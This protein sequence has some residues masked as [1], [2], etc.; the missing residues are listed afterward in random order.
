MIQLLPKMY[1]LIFRNIDPLS[2]DMVVP[3]MGVIIEV[4]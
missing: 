1:N 4:G 3:T 2:I